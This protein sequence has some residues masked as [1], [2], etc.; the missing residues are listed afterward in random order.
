MQNAI[1]YLVCVV[2]NQ[3]ITTWWRHQ[4]ETFSKLLAL[5]AWNSPVNVEFPSQRPVTWS[6]DA[7]FDLRI[8]KRLSKQSWGRWFETPSCLLWRHCTD[9]VC[10]QFRHTGACYYQPVQ[11]P[12]HWVW[13]TISKPVFYLNW[14]PC[15]FSSSS[16][17][18]LRHTSKNS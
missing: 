15:I 1:W 9:L 16:N 12:I 13:Y 4:M 7:F 6:F 18:S 2:W 14:V 10:S 5:C 17:L 8:N 3:I 11:C